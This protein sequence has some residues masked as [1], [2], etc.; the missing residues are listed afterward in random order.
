MIIGCA[1]TGA[2]Y[3]LA[4]ADGLLDKEFGTNSWLDK[5]RRA[6]AFV[7]AVFFVISCA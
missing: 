1:V 2:I 6:Q 3:P 4:F 7:R 5:L